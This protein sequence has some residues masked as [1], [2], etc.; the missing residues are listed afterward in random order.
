[1]RK[2]GLLAAVA[3]GLAGVSLASAQEVQVQ[4]QGTVS[5]GQPPPQQGP[6]YQPAPPPPG[7]GQ[8][9]YQ[10]PVYGQPVYQQPV[11][12]QPQPYYVQPQPQQPRYVERQEAITPL[13]VSGVVLLPVSYLLTALCATAGGGPIDYIAW[14]WVPLIG[15]WFAL[16]YEE[17]FLN[18][19]EIGGA[20]LG[21]VL[22]ASGLLLIILGVSIRQTVRVATYSLG[23]GERAPE[24]AFGVSPN[25]VN[26]SL[27][28]F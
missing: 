23:D 25:G 6:V 7:Y 12:A 18:S 26:L 19:E 20:I 17:E 16:G 11:Y 27:T 9:V 4:G 28:H 13:W 1:M 22:Q 21:G 3:V 2:L 24:L 8:P 15:P 10:Q 14:N 5:I